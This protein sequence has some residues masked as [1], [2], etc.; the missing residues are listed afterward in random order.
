MS[1]HLFLFSITPVQAFIEQAR[2]TQDL[3]A[4]SKILSHL[5][6]TAIEASGLTPKQI[7]FPGYDP[8]SIDSGYCLPNRFLARFDADEST[9]KDLGEK[10]EK[11]VKHTFR[12]MAER[13]IEKHTG[14][15]ELS[16]E[17][18]RQIDTYLTINWVFVPVNGKYDDAYK[19]IERYLGAI[20]Q[21]RMFE[22]FEQA[23]G[24]KC[25]ICG[26]RNVKFYR[27]TDEETKH[28]RIPAKLFL[29]DPKQVKIWNYTD[30]SLN[31]KFLQPG[32]GLCAVCFAKRGAEEYFKQCQTSSY[33]PDFLST[34]DIAIK[35]ALNELREKPVEIPEEHDAH[36]LFA[37]KNHSQKAIDEARD[38]FSKEVFMHS[39][40]LLALF[41]KHDVT[42]S[43]YY[44]VLRFDGD[45]MG[46][47][48]NG[49][50]GEIEDLQG[51]HPK[52]SEKLA[53]FSAQVVEY[54]KTY[55]ERGKAVYIGGDDFLGFLSLRSMFTVMKDLRQLFGAIVLRPFTERT[56]TF[57]ASLIVAHYKTPLSE[58]LKLSGGMEKDAKKID[59]DKDAFAVV[60][61][62]H[63]G[64]AQQAIFKW[65]K[66]KQA[67][68]TTELFGNIADRIRTEKFSGTFLNS[69]EIELRKLMNS[70][71][72]FSETPLIRAE[73]KR[74]I[75]RSQM[76]KKDAENA[77]SLLREM[78]QDVF[79]LFDS[80][81]NV[82]NFLSALGII[83]F[84]TRKVAQS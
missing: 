5:C 51:F 8:K 49:N 66:D 33:D 21:V 73:I 18:E 6:R 10:V 24:R 70:D 22:Q 82:K 58:V 47:W 68:W 64:E 11:A 46:K 19:Q 65:T 30:K 25:A 60:A 50:G 41:K 3:Y 37:L 71:G 27:K 1:E 15:K 17:E 23:P 53:E 29:A 62:R 13:V 78:T 52:L 32:E 72:T 55:P 20:K 83:D 45:S 44:A 54:F 77:E 12:D 2:K 63:S 48:L 34:A 26:E 80:S 81:R 67:Q 7:I 16:P 57:S 35:D 40:G 28:A 79:E 76:D 74:L 14:R 61:L 4:G 38:Q 31:Q 56:P 69:L 84:L 43:P 75:E 9:L 42:P 36:L 39:E 59:D